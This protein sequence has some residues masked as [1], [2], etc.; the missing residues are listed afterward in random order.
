[1]VFQQPETQLFEETVG[2]DVSFSPRRKK[3]PAERSRALVESSLQSV[4]LDYQT[5]RLRYVYALSGGQKRRVAIAGI[6][7]GEPEVLI[8]DEP[9]AGLDPR[10]RRELAALVKHLAHERNLTVIL[11]GNTIDELA[12][13]ADRAIVMHEGK[14]VSDG[15]LL[16]VLRESAMLHRIGLELSEAAEIARLIRQQRPTFPAHFLHI[17]ALCDAICAFTGAA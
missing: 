4:G 1:M 3:L 2:K 11:V 6:L 8:L 9:V 7:A 16:Q 17:E 15:P 14:V 10:G 12:E 5:F 13:L